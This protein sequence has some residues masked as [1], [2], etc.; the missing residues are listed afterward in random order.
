MNCW[1]VLVISDLV[2][3]KE[4]RYDNLNQTSLY[5][6]WS[7]TTAECD[8]NRYFRKPRCC[9]LR[10]SSITVR[11]QVASSQPLLATVMRNSR[12]QPSLDGISGRYTKL[13]NEDATSDAK[14]IRVN[15]LPH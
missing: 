9:P 7:E 4:R 12:C 2:V 14:F 1:R 6:N 13:G 5:R 3:T 10:S 15:T 8:A 11:S